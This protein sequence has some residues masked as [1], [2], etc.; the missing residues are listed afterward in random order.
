MTVGKREPQHLTHWIS[1]A[2]I[3]GK[4][5]PN[6]K[7][8]GNISLQW[9]GHIWQHKKY[10]TKT[11]NAHPLNLNSAFD[12]ARQISGFT[13]TKE[14]KREGKS[15]SQEMSKG[16][17][18][19]QKTH[20]HRGTRCR[21]AARPSCRGRVGSCKDPCCSARLRTMRTFSALV[22]HTQ[23]CIPADGPAG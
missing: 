9:G 22:P 21:P 8:I 1:L 10:R 6:T 17:A 14:R 19:L 12:K 2:Q 5:E 23:P 15:R 18:L 4:R 7:N 16:S 20:L 11:G 3:M 13:Q